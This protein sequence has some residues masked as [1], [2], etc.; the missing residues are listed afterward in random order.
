MVLKKLK[1]YYHETQTIIISRIYAITRS[2]QVLI[3]LLPTL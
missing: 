3:G 1:M 2:Q